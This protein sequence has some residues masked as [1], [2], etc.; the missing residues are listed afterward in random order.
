[1]SLPLF[2]LLKLFIYFAFL[3]SKTSCIFHPCEAQTQCKGMFIINELLF[4]S[5]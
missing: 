2:F 4:N 3:L 5:N 1:M